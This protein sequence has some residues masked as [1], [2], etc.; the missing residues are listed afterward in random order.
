L[1]L[2]VRLLLS[3]ELDVH[4]FKRHGVEFGPVVHTF[5]DF[6]LV[7]ALLNWILVFGAAYFF[8]P[9]LLKRFKQSASSQLRG[10]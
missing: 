6:S 4:L 9:R 1:Q 5:D 3:E 7:C 2:A 10:E 8:F